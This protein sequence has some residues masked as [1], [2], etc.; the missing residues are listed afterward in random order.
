MGSA[1][2]GVFSHGL[3]KILGYFISNAVIGLRIRAGDGRLLDDG[4]RFEFVILGCEESL[5]LVR[6]GLGFG[7]AF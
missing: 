1:P 6:E 5:G 4:P 2:R 7:R 3:G